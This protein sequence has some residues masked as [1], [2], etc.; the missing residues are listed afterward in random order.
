MEILDKAMHLLHEVVSLI[1]KGNT[2]Y[3]FS[4]SPSYLS[5]PPPAATLSQYFP[6]NS[7][8]SPQVL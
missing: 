6:L 5:S 2:L 3:H 7:P 8:A 1:L 4:A